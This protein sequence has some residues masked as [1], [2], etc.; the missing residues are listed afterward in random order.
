M[1]M[2]I[3]ITAAKINIKPPM[4]KKVRNPR[5]NPFFFFVVA[6]TMIASRS[7][8]VDDKRFVN[9]HILTK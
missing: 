3:P 6:S 8:T 1:S 4:A 2:R 7:W 5:Q 9:D